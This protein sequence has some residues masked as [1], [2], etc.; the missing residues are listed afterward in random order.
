MPT[1]RVAKA[2][3]NKVQRK[4][5]KYSICFL[6]PEANCL[7]SSTKLWSRTLFF[8]ENFHNNVNW[9]LRVVDYVAWKRRIFKAT[10]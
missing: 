9:V 7:F 3:E 6:Y 10:L 8:T 4:T 2:Y 1:Y 5:R